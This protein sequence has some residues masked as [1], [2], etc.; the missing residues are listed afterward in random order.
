MPVEISE[1]QIRTLDL[2]PLQAWAS[3]DPAALVQRAGSLELNFDWP[4]A[5]DDPRELSEIAELRLWSLRADAEYPWLPLVL[6]RGSGQLTRHGAMLLPHQF[7]RTEGIR[8]APE[9]LELWMT[10]RLFGLDAWAR[11]HNLG[12]R[13]GLTQMAAVLGFELD[14]QFWVGLPPV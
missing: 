2:A 1:Q 9:A 3:L 14:A 5:A 12:I 13:Q 8:F 10:H 7:S 4:K 11:S 6:E